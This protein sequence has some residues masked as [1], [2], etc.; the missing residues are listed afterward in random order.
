MWTVP[1]ISE[2]LSCALATLPNHNSALSRPSNNSVAMAGRASPARCGN[3]LFTLSSSSLTDGEMATNEPNSSM[4]PPIQIQATSGRT[5]TR[6]VPR[7]VSGL[8]LLMMT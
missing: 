6:N 4:R 3:G 1:A 2:L 8:T 7:F 5:M